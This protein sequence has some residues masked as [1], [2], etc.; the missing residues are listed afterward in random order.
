[1]TC[2]CPL[3]TEWKLAGSSSVSPVAQPNSTM[4]TAAQPASSERVQWS[5]SEFFCEIRGKCDCGEKCMTAICNAILPAAASIAT[6]AAATE[7]H[8]RTDNSIGLPS[9]N[10]VLLLPRCVPPASLFQ[11][12]RLRPTMPRGEREG[13]AATKGLLAHSSVGLIQPIEGC[14]RHH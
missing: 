4:T 11:E 8:R 2:K 5:D 13:K 10:E 12:L 3:K 7:G 14:V 9:R 1:M 6:R